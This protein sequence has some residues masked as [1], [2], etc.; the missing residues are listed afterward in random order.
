[1]KTF[2][3]EVQ[4]SGALDHYS[5]SDKQRQQLEEILREKLRRKWESELVEAADFCG[6]TIREFSP[7]TM[8]KLEIL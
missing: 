5:V 6:L 1:M 7:I 3:M 8:G 4:I 2:Y